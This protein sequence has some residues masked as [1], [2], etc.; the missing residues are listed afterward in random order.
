MQ[1]H[2]F[3]L[4]NPHPWFV[5][6]IEMVRVLWSAGSS[7]KVKINKLKEI[8]GTYESYRITN[9]VDLRTSRIWEGEKSEIVIHFSENII[10][11]LK[12]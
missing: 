8:I 2:G 4:L 1:S 5:Y 10:F 9:K 6:N 7:S 12:M 3:S 11:I